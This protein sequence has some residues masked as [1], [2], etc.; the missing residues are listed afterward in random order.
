MLALR[1]IWKTYEGQP[2]LRGISLHVEPEETLGVLGP[3]GS[4]KSTLLRIIAG[5]EEPERGQVFWNGADITRL[6][7]NRRHFGLMFQDYALFPHLDVGANV[8]F[9]LRLQNLPREKIAE[10]V[11]ESLEWVNLRGFD[12]RRVME[13][14]GG[15]QQRVALARTLASAPQLLMLDEPLGALDRAL[16][17][18]LS[19]ELRGLLRRLRIP[20]IY[21][22]HD[23]EEAFAVA[24]RIAILHQG[25][26]VQTGSVTE[27]IARPASA[28]VA[29]FLGLGNL[30]RGRV[31]STRPLR[32]MT[33]LGEFP[34][35]TGEPAPRAGEEGWLLL[36]PGAGRVHPSVRKPRSC[37]HG[38]VLE[39]NPRENSHRITLRCAGD[40]EVSFCS[41]ESYLPG[42]KLY[43]LPG[44]GLYLR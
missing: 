7:T 23:Q 1:N 38:I 42:M 14:S 27:L 4:G 20:T 13:L 33:A 28:W 15:E 37:I 39:T 26:F 34:A 9:G 22:T 8:G 12:R 24:S 41:P 30:L 11:H 19:G 40:L 31:S 16:R 32:F 21:V 29:N 36:R 44:K 6:P 2:L 43:W 25:Q 18:E 3:S 5:L 17:E 35:D 10:T